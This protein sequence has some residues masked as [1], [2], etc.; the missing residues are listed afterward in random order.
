VLKALTKVLGP[1]GTL[2][3]PA[4]SWALVEQGIRVFEAGDTPSCVG[5]IAEHFRKMPG[6]QRSL[7]PTHSVAAIGP[8]SSSLTTG[9]ENCST[10]CG[11]GSPYEKLLNQGGQILFLGVNLDSNT[12]FHTIEALANLSYLMRHESHAF[13][14]V[15][16]AGNRKLISL[17]LHRG[18]I[19]RRFGEWE[20]LL[21]EKGILK[22]GAVG[23]A[24]SCLLDGKPFLD[25]ML[26]E[27]RK[28]PNMFLI[29]APS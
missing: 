10:P 9:H 16:K 20:N 7:H 29:A 18:G 12:T 3:L 1:W 21:Y 15:D 6:V 28:N 22:R 11:A 4:H 8:L 17:R 24:R 14:I 19:P 2:V 5:V 25:C 27:V 26:D 13:T 23:N